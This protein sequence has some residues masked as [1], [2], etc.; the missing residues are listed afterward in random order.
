MVASVTDAAA[1]TASIPALVVQCW[2]K[3]YGL[4]GV[5]VLAVSAMMV[6][7]VLAVIAAFG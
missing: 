3:Q 5:T 7:T 2:P 4:M 1:A 6:V